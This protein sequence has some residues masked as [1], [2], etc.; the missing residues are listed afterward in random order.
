MPGCHW[1]PPPAAD[2]QNP[3]QPQ[4]RAGQRAGR[5]KGVFPKLAISY[6]EAGYRTHQALEANFPK[7]TAKEPTQRSAWSQ[8]WGIEYRSLHTSAEWT[9]LQVRV[10]EKA[11]AIHT[12]A[13]NKF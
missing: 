13:L 2:C 6:W 3:D 7:S 9:L 8:F 4:R 12:A 5:F 1:Y 11:I 10:I